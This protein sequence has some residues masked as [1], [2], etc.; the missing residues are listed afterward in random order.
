MQRLIIFYTRRGS[1]IVEHEVVTNKTEQANQ[2]LVESVLSLS[3]GESKIEY[4][5]NNLTASSVAVT[6]TSGKQQ[7]M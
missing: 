6:D 7:G 4:G 1:T 2:D 3:K 5:S